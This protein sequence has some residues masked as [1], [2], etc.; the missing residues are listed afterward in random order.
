MVPVE[1]GDGDEHLRD[2]VLQQLVRRLDVVRVIAHEAAVR[3]GV[4]IADGQLLHTG[5]Q[6]RAQLTHDDGARLEHKAVEQVSSS[7]R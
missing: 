4:K 2:A 3:I 5:K 6:L 7:R 1:R